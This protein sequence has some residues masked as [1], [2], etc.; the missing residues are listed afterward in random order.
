KAS[1]YGGRHLIYLSRYCVQDDPFLSLDLAGAT[2][3]AADSLKRMFP[4]FS[5]AMICTAHTW[6]AQ[7]AQP[8]VTRGYRRLVPPHEP[9]LFRLYI[10]TMAQIY[11]EDR[12][13]N[14]AIR[15]GR[16]VAAK[17]ADVL[18]GARG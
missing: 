18:A 2:A 11:P 9:P 4:A 13:T 5:P 8:I 6:Q 17:L 12:G 10:A 1:D 3:Y 7:W 16:K 15:D 14:Y